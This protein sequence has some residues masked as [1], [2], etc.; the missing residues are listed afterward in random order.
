MK[1]SVTLK[2]N[3]HFVGDLDGFDIPLDAGA[4]FG[5]RS[6]GPGP[7]GLMLT[8]LAGCTAMDVISLLRKMEQ[9]PEHFSVETE[10]DVAGEHPR[11]FTA[12]RLVYRLKGDLDREKV[13][14]AVRLSQ[15]RYCGVNA[16][17]KKA[18]PVSYR[19]VIDP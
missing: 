3:M 2:H 16:M 19:I 4:V 11:V 7:K 1:S 6:K 13:E 12:V 18:A 8:A 17:L 14:K 9:E 5:G 15:E 10:A